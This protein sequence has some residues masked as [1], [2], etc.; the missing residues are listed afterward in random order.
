M[1]EILWRKGTDQGLE[2]WVGFGLEVGV[3]WMLS[4]VGGVP[5]QDSEIKVYLEYVL[6]R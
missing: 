6:Y 1:S 2:R 5:S 4:D 3:G